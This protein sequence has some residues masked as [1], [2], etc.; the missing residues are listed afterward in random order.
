VDEEGVRHVN[1]GSVSWPG[2][3]SMKHRIR[4]PLELVA[5]GI[6]YHSRDRLWTCVFLSFYRRGDVSSLQ[7]P[8]GMLL[9][10]D[11]PQEN[12]RDLHSQ[13]AITIQ[14]LDSPQ[15]HAMINVR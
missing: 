6:D 3:F 12:S 13:V 7:L 9:I 5:F 10:D 1:L 14:V 15:R 8:S 11:I 4:R 2:Y